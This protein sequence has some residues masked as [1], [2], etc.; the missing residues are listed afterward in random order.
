MLLFIVVNN[1]LQPTCTCTLVL[2]I[3]IPNTL[4]VVV[5][6]LY[7]ILE[8]CTVVV[9]NSLNHINSLVVN[10]SLHHINTLMVNTSLH[11]INTSY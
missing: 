10:I 5:T 11:H 4:R 6:F 3:L 7:D 1:S 9:N 8:H 2:N